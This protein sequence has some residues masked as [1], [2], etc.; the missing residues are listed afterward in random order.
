MVGDQSPPVRAPARVPARLRTYCEPRL[1]LRRRGPRGIGAARMV[2]M[3]G[4]RWREPVLA[5][6]LELGS[7]S[8]HAMTTRHKLLVSLGALG[9]VVLLWRIDLNAGQLEL[10]HVWWGMA[11]VLGHEILAHGRDASGLR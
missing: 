2:P 6:P 8:A 1:Y 7:C 4:S 5:Q 9:L 10:F 11:L 3:G